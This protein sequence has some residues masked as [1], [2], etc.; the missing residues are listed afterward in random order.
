PNAA[1]NESADFIFGEVMVIDKAQ[2]EI[3]IGSEIFQGPFKTLRHSN[4][5]DG[6][7]KRATQPV[8]RQLLTGVYVLQI[9][10]PMRALDDLRG[11]IVTSNTLDQFVV[12]FAGIFSDENVTRAPQIPGRLAQ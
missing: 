11:P 1:L 8:Q 2:G 3:H 7:D 6:A 9:E 4:R 12:R 5:A 10:R